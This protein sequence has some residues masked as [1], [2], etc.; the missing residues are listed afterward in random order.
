MVQPQGVQD[1]I[2]QMKIPGLTTKNAERGLRIYYEKKRQKQQ[3]SSKE[4]QI[5]KWA[6]GKLKM[7]VA[8]QVRVAPQMRVEPL[9]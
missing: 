1:V 6:Q 5:L 9:K 7:R 8:P 4:L 2:V 3:L